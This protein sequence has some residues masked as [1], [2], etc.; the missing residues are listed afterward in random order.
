MRKQNH[1]FGNTRFVGPYLAALSLAMLAGC[2]DGTNSGGSEGGSNS[3]SN[4][5]SSGDASSSSSSGGGGSGGGG[6]SSSSSS[7]GGMQ[8]DTAVGI[9]GT[10]QVQG[11][12]IVDKSGTPVQ[13]RGMSLFWS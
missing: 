1:F 12:K 5:S 13:L 11:N 9:H 4:N 3:S 10:L 6:A 2:G 8:T 7:S